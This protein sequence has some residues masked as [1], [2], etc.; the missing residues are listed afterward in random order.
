MTSACAC[1]T[2]SSR[3]HRPPTSGSHICTPAR[4][5]SAV[6]DANSSPENARSYSPTTTASNR[7]SGEGSSASNA[8][9]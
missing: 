3:T 6:T 2:G 8:A 9:A 4:S 5:N 7:R 1:A